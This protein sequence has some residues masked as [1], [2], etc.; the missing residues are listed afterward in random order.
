MMSLIHHELDGDPVENIQ[1]TNESSNDITEIMHELGWDLPPDIID[2]LYNEQ[3]TK[4]P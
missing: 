4:S 2:L 1:N 3:R